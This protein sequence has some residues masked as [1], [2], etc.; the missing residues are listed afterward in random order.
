[1]RRR[2]MLGSLIAHGFGGPPGVGRLARFGS[3]LSNLPVRRFLLS[4]AFSYAA[5]AALLVVLT[6]AFANLYPSSLGMSTQ[7]AYSAYALAILGLTA[8]IPIIITMVFSGALADRFRRLPLMRTV[9][10]VAITATGLLAILTIYPATG[11]VYL[12]GPSGFY[13]PLW[14]LLVLPLWATVTVTSTIFR[15][16]FNASLP[17]LMLTAD[18]ASANSL[19]YLVALVV[20]LPGDLLT[21][22]IYQFASPAWAFAVPFVF[23]VVTGVYLRLLRSD[24]DPAQR[25]PRR[26]FFS[27]ALDGYRYLGQRTEVLQVTLGALAINFLNAVAYVELGLY[28]TRWLMLSSP[29][30]VGAMIYAATAGAGVGTFVITRISFERRA[31]RFLAL[32]ALLEGA[33]VLLLA[34]S[35]SIWTSLPIFFLFGLFPGMFTIVFLAT[36]QATVPNDRLG[37]VLAADEIG[38]YSLVPV[39]QYAGGLITL[40]TGVQLTYVIAGLG[41]VAVGGI[42]ASLRR[43]SRLGF[44]PSGPEGLGPTPREEEGPLPGGIPTGP[45]ISDPSSP[46]EG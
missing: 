14:A 28:V 27:D 5:P 39:G 4:G 40:V 3:L 9:N 12:P 25:A 32:F 7:T 26:H 1:V 20:S 16:T 45:V 29:I 18:L 33:M 43:L 22:Y 21:P 36:V 13:L 17:R 41:T 46:G 15:P 2:R 8:T 19:V 24:L 31:G 30:F 42:M 38:S 37:R 10:L 44:D 35:Q 34:F 11:P 23:F 6:W